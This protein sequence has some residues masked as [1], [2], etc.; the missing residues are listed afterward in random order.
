MDPV[1][2]KV[3][4]VGGFVML[5]GPA[6]SASLRDGSQHQVSGILPWMVVVILA[7]EL[8]VTSIRAVVETDGGDF[9]ADWSGKAKMIVQAGAIPA[10]L[11]TL[12]ITEIH[13]GSWGRLAID[14]IA[15]AT[16]AITV[17]SGIPYV[18]RGIA[19][20]RPTLPNP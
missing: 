9:S 16:L 5:A 14:S 11:V 15:W 17:L 2:D 6:F 12:G 1:A 10:I 19:L 4:V 7:R 8:L 18:R 3:L 13:Q 20:S